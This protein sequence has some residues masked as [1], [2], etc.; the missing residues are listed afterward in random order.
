MMRLEIQTETKTPGLDGMAEVEFV[1]VFLDGVKITTQA[2][3]F[4][5]SSPEITLHECDY[6][7]QCGVPTIAVRKIADHSVIWFTNPDHG[8]EDDVARE[9]LRIFNL[10]AYETALNS[11]TTDLPQ[12]STRDLRHL[13][14]LEQFPDWSEVLYSLPEIDGDE[15]G[16]D[17][18]RVIVDS[19]SNLSITPIALHV[20]EFETVTFGYDIDK[21][22]ETQI[23]FAMLSNEIIFRFRSTP[24]L[25]LWIKI[26]PKPN[27]FVALKRHLENAK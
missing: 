14:S 18:M 13:I 4:D 23:D 7:Y 22:L 1:H 9:E 24:H 27:G 15:T 8:R 3:F 5:A 12:I 20:P 6:C 26:V 11:K 25:P 17:T 2:A 21:L 10:K 16:A 19:I